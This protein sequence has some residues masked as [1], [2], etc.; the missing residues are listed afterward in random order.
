MK[1]A[2][3]AITT[4][5]ANCMTEVRIAKD[6]GYDGIEFTAH[7]IKRF[8]DQ[9]H[10][11]RLLADACLQAGT[12]AI[13]INALVEAEDGNVKSRDELLDE[14]QLLSSIAQRLD[15]PT[16]QLVFLNHAPNV[17]WPQI[18]RPMARL[19]GELADIGAD[20]SVQYQLEPIAWS[21]WHSLSQS[22]QVIEEAN[23]RNVGMVI[24]F[25]H[26]WAGRQTTPDEVAQLDP[27]L[28]Y[29]VHICDGKR[30]HPSEPWSEGKLRGYRLGDGDVPIADWVSAIKATGYDGFWSP[31]TFSPVHWEYDL[32][33]FAEDARTR[34]QS[35]TG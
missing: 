5:H 3:H 32:F 4:M 9:G 2:L 13:C 17:S 16:I 7:K 15:C 22:L 14:C 21:P 29:G 31:E 11:I 25:W 1:I 33:D 10:D 20:Y 19:V 34:I 26:L 23:R 35:Y 28:I 27:Q 12:P 6:L 18:R 24:D 30:P 8:I